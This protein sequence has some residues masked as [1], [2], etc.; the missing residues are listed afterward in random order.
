MAE[1]DASGYYILLNHSSGPTGPFMLARPSSLPV[2]IEKA[3]ALF[4][5]DQI[6]LSFNIAG[7]KVRVTEDAWGTT[8]LKRDGL[9]FEGVVLP[10][11]LSL[12]HAHALVGASS[13]Q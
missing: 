5:L 9:E 8:A 13:Q 12:C 10:R 4:Q 1:P 3:R 11:P 7:R 6:Y 2:A